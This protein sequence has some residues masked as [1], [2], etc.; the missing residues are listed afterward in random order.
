MVSSV[1][2][3]LIVLVV[4]ASSSSSSLES[5]SASIL[6]VMTLAI[7]GSDVVVG[8]VMLVLSSVEID[9]FLFFTDEKKSTRWN[10]Y[11][12]TALKRWHG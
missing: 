5:I 7:I 2:I 11:W 6:S 3:I 12:R 1:S 4:A 10:V 8:G 9:V